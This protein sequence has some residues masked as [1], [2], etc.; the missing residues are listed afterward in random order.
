MFL[1]SL[2]IINASTILD[3]I[4]KTKLPYLISR[5]KQHCNNAQTICTLKL[6]ILAFEM[7]YHLKCHNSLEDIGQQPSRNPPWIFFLLNINITINENNRTA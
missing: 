5:E 3:L 6:N 7:I 2:K 4:N 1:C